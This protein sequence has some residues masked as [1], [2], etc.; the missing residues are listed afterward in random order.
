M[1]AR[2][3]GG[4]RRTRPPSSVATGSPAR[5]STR[6]APPGQPLRGRGAGHLDHA[7]ASGAVRAL[8]CSRCTMGLARSS[9]TRTGSGRRSRTW[10]STAGQRRPRRRAAPRRHH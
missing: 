1:R 3:A 7:H 2:S 4:G 6:C 8:L 5:R 10:R 9:T